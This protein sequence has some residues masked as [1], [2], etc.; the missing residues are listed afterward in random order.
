MLI[1]M[2]ARIPTMLMWRNMHRNLSMDQCRLWRNE[3]IVLLGQCEECTVY[4]RP[5]KYENG[6]ANAMSSDVSQ[7]KTV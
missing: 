6:K 7:A 1:G 5:I 4:F 2:M 3:S